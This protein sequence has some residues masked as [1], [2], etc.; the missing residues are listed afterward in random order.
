MIISSK[1]ARSSVHFRVA[2]EGVHILAFRQN[3]RGRHA[4]GRRD[5]HVAQHGIGAQNEGEQP[6]DQICRR[7]VAGGPHV[8]PLKKT[9]GQGET[10]KAI[11]EN[12]ESGNARQ[13]P[14]KAAQG[15]DQRI[16]PD[17]GDAAAVPF[18]PLLPAPLDADQKTYGNRKAGP[19]HNFGFTHGRLE[20]EC[21]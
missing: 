15:A 2:N 6:R 17:A 4:R 13:K 18:L 19:L 1:A 3:C 10:H 16:S 21:V 14:A 8:L 9:E 7:K 20:A 11:T 12:G 5:G